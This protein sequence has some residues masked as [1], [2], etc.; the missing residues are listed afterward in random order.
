MLFPRA[1]LN[2]LWTLVGARVGLTALTASPIVLRALGG[3]S[4]NL[5]PK[6]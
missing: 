1:F 3:K 4:R 2:A 6:L 5:S